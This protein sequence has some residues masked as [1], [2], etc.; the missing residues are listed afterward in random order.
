[1]PLFDELPKK[2]VPMFKGLVV[3]VATY[4]GGASSCGFTTSRAINGKQPGRFSVDFQQLRDAADEKNPEFWEAI[5]ALLDKNE[6]DK[7]G[8]LLSK[9]EAK[10]VSILF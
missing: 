4:A 1:M 7:V 6:C 3:Q 9:K 10:E 8:F 5:Q 2:F